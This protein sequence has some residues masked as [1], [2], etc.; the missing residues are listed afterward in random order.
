MPKFSVN[1]EG[2]LSS[3]DRNF[4]RQIR[5]WSL[6]QLLLII[7]LLLLLMHIIINTQ[8][9]Y[10]VSNKGLYEEYD[11]AKIWK[12]LVLLLIPV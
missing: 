8:Y 2:I 12:Q 10:Y 9:N 7:A 1:F 4:E 5:S 6:A 11:T 3:V